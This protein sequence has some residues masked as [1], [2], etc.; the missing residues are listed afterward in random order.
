MLSIKRCATKDSSLYKIEIFLSYV[1]LAKIQDFV[2]FVNTV[3]DH[4]ELER[5]I[6]QFGRLLLST[7]V[8]NRNLLSTVM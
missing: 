3:L 5:H 7:A 2:V 1:T 4:R 8:Q 6:R